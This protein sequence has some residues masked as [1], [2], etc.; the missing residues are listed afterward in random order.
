MWKV[1]D[2]YKNKIL[3]QEEDIMYQLN[4]TNINQNFNWDF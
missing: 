4:S 3:P 2:E 1:F